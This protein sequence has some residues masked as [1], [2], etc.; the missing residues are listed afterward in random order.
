MNE[1]IQNPKIKR[2]KLHEGYGFIP[3]QRTDIFLYSQLTPP[4]IIR[5]VIEIEQPIHADEL[6]KRVVTVFGAQ[7]VSAKT[8]RSVLT[9]IRTPDSFNRCLYDDIQYDGYFVKMK[10]FDKLQVR[11]PNK[12]DKYVRSVQHVPDDELGMAMMIIAKTTDG[13]TPENLFIETARE[14]GFKKAG[15]SD[16]DSIRKAYRKL[17]RAEK[18]KEVD[19]NV[20]VMC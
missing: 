20:Y 18:V 8:Q 14:F 16:I 9:A 15:E 19:G 4:E 12:N 3:Y 5:K 6:Y 17:L 13:I 2:E 7:K 11:V 10:T 1:T